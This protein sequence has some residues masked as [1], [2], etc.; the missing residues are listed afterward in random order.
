[1]AGFDSLTSSISPQDDSGN[2]NPYELDDDYKNQGKTKRSSK[3]VKTKTMI[4]DLVHHVCLKKISDEV[5]YLVN[6]NG[7]IEIHPTVQ[8]KGQV[9]RPKQDIPFTC[10]DNEILEVEPADSVEVLYRTEQFL[11]SFIELPYEQ[12][13]LIVAL[14]IGHTYFVDEHFDVTPILNVYGVKE[15]GKTR[16]GELVALT[17]YRGERCTSPTEATFFRAAQAFKST[18]VIDELKLWG[19]DGRRDVADL[20]KSRY[21]RGMKVSRCNMNKSG[22]D[23]I[24]YF[25]VY[26]PLVICSTESVPPIIKTRCIT[27]V[28]QQNADPSVEGEID[29]VEAQWIREQWTLYRLK[30][31]NEEIPEVENK[32]RRRLREITQPLLRVCEIID[33]SRIDEVLD[34]IDY[35]SLIKAEEEGES[36]EAEILRTIY[37]CRGLLSVDKFR[38][39]DITDSLNRG[40]SEKEKFSAKFVSACISRMGFEKTRVHGG[41]MGFRYDGELMH[42]LLKKYELNLDDEIGLGNTE[43]ENRSVENATSPMERDNN[44]VPIFVKK[45]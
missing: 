34:Y 33:K 24:E 37:K 6:N 1:M 44:E 21:K 26:A 41:K 5:C 25:D 29:Q 7:K 14:Y 17:A 31:M 15:T 3:N 16:L 38:T 9:Y 43:E 40:R 36:T 10:L 23:A 4:P 27:I 30:W 12:L 2:F 28:M 20:I 35:M 45:D 32:A 19:K 8:I 22:E 18:L 11:R 13:Y 39:T 42:K